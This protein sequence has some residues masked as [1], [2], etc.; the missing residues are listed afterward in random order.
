MNRSSAVVLALLSAAALSGCGGG[1]ASSQ[2]PDFSLAAR[3]GGTITLSGQKGRVVLVNFWATW[4]DSCKDE[5][6]VLQELQR[7]QPADRFELLAVSVDDDPAKA[8]PPF[9]DARG[10][11]FPILYGDRRTE[12]AY[13]VR[14]LP[15]SFLIAPDGTIA[16][17]YVG[18]LDER[19]VENDILSLLNRRPS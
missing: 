11:N 8:V 19:A 13:A 5:L 15:T 6:P 10:L 18:P 1:D 7:T 3:Q 9:A 17:R 12:A 16:R 4:C 14:A 2:A